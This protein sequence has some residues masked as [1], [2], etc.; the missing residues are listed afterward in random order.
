MTK[1]FEDA[2][3]R[4]LN[5]SNCRTQVELAEV[6]GIR[7]SS[8][9][10]AKRRGTVPAEWLLTLLH[11]FGANPDWILTGQDTQFLEF[12]EQQPESS[13]SDD[14]ISGTRKL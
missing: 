11:R 10:D 6:L 13:A 12:T 8:V 7:Q 4:I 1:N 5:I 2:Y 3:T 14:R 9:S